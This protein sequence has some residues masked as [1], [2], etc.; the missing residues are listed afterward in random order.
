M[1]IPGRRKKDGPTKAVKELA[2][3]CILL[4]SGG[5]FAGPV[6]KLLH[7]SD[8]TLFRYVADLKEAGLIPDLRSET[9]DG[10]TEF[11][12]D[13]DDLYDLTE[14]DP[15]AGP[16]ADPQLNR[17]RR[18]VLIDWFF[19]EQEYYD[20]Y[21][22]PDIDFEPGER[23]YAAQLVAWLEEKGAA[24]VSLRS[25]QRDVRDVLEARGICREFEE[26]YM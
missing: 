3:Y 8:R 11:I 15:P 19:C 6:R 25:V 1:E 18:L 24:G 10:K 7:V 20:T 12:F 26:R 2:L 16:L 14:D 4:V 23:V 22:D 17:M 5:F 21:F 9:T 13:R